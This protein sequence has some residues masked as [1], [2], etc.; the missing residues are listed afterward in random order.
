M[1]YRLHDMRHTAATLLHAGKSISTVQQI[2]G[3]VAASTNVNIYGHVIEG[4]KRDASAAH[5]RMLQGKA[6]RRLCSRSCS[7]TAE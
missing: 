5:D 6:D 1:Q 2:L 4:A 7:K 3:H